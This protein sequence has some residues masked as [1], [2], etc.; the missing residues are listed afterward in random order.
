MAV[1]A[2]VPVYVYPCEVFPQE[3]LLPDG[4]RLELIM[5]PVDRKHI[6]AIEKDEGIQLIYKK[7]EIADILNSHY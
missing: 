6:N 2:K 1:K 3:T 4:N 7:E 5:R